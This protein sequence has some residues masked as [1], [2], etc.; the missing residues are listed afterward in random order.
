MDVQDPSSF[1]PPIPT[2]FVSG[3]FRATKLARTFYTYDDDDNL[4]ETRYIETVPRI[5]LN[6]EDNEFDSRQNGVNVEDTTTKWQK[7]GDN[8]W[9]KVTINRRSAALTNTSPN[10][11]S[12]AVVSTSNTTTSGT[13]E[14]QPPRA[15]LWDGGIITEDVEYQATVN[16][17]QPGGSSG[18]TRK[19]LYTVP[20]G[21]SQA[22]CETLAQLHLKLVAGQHRAVA[23]EMPVTDA[24]LTAPPLFAFD[25][26]EPSG[27]RCHYRADS[28]AW[29]HS[30]DTC[31]AA[32]T[33]IL[34]GI[35]P[36][37]TEGNPNPDPEPVTGTI[38]VA[39]GI[40]VE[41]SGIQ[42]YATT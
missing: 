41:A 39:G 32:A 13:G 31:K 3:G 1:L 35:T 42:V 22:Q 2:V 26:V 37:P 33:G 16:Y 27:R 14:N 21:F 12:S 19:R 4:T 28:L 29:E 5:I 40:P 15:E 7:Q 10:I 36:A 24:L 23:V 18:R 38:V 20:Y 25:V 17:T 30:A 8:T 6:K 34:V 11:S 9:R